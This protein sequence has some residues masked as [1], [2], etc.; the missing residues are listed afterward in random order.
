MALS[1][2]YTDTNARKISP[3]QHHALSSND[4]SSAILSCRCILCFPS[5]T[6]SLPWLIILATVMR[7]GDGKPVGANVIP[8]PPSFRKSFSSS[9]FPGLAGFKLNASDTVEQPNAAECVWRHG[10]TTPSKH[11]AISTPLSFRQSRLISCLLL[12]HTNIYPQPSLQ[13]ANRA[14]PSSSAAACSISSI[15]L[16]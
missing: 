7:E 16:R 12:S 5:L 9:L 6:L 13:P 15:W 10:L 2:W 3:F 1:L 8:T 14:P 4:S 11:H